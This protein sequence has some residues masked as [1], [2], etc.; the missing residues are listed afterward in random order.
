VSVFIDRR[1]IDRRSEEKMNKKGYLEA[2]DMH[3]TSTC[4]VPTIN[5]VVRGQQLPASVSR[6]SVRPAV[7][8]L[9]FTP[10]AGGDATA[11]ICARCIK[12]PA[13][14]PGGHHLGRGSD[15]SAQG[16]DTGLLLSTREITSRRGAQPMPRRQLFS[17]PVKYGLSASGHIAGVS[18]AGANMSLGARGKPPTP[19]EWRAGATQRTDSWCRLENGGPRNMPAAPSRRASPGDGKLHPDRGRT[20]VLR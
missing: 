16:Q 17:G 8:E 11:F 19:D 9:G 5:L 12:R 3:T 15:R 10:H 20:R 6:F 14:Q 2:R 13:R 4:C 18:P 7:L 1:T